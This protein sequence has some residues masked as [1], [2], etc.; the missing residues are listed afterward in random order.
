VSQQPANDPGPIFSPEVIESARMLI[1]GDVQME[2]EAFLRYLA[3][4]MDRPLHE[5]SLMMSAW[6]HNKGGI[7]NLA[8]KARELRHDPEL[9]PLFDQ[10]KA[11]LP[12]D[13]GNAPGPH[14]AL[15]QAADRKRDELIAELS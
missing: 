14:K 5:R 10:I 11:D 8:R 9:I 7:F 3:T 12:G 4:R 15:L 2:A 13:G 6:C 1:R